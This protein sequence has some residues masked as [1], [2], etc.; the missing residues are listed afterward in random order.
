MP[1]PEWKKSGESAIGN[2]KYGLKCGEG[3]YLL[4]RRI[5]GRI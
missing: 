5:D 2:H 3:T 1:T 4:E